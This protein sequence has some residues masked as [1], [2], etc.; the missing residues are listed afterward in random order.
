VTA[1]HRRVAIQQEVAHGRPALQAARAL[2]DLGLH[3]DA[4]NRLY[5]ALFHHVVALLLIEGVEPRRRA[6]IPG[7]L[8]QHVVG[9]HELTVADVALI[10]R[11]NTYR[12]LADYERTWVADEGIAGTAFA[13][14]EPLLG[15][16][17]RYLGAAGWLD[18][19]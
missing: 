4:L 14:V 7:L 19:A 1:D 10:S 8:G 17:A 13:E 3:N 2:R 5:Y 6:S 12:D 18:A 15:R 9:R 11:T 16:I